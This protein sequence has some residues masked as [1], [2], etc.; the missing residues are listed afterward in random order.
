MVDGPLSYYSHEDFEK[1]NKQQL[2]FSRKKNEVLGYFSIELIKV[3][4]R[5]KVRL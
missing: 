4:V 5:I 1:R 3:G 2:L